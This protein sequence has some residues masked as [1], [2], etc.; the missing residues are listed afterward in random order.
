M[1][2]LKV[3]MYQLKQRYDGEYAPN[4]EAIWDENEIDQNPQGWAEI[5]DKAYKQVGGEYENVAVITIEVKDDLYAAPQYPSQ[6]DP[7]WFSNSFGQ[8]YGV[9]LIVAEHAD[10]ETWTQIEDVWDEY[11]MEENGEGYQEAVAKAFAKV[12]QGVNWVKVEDIFIPNAV[13]DNA[14][15]PWKQVHEAL[16]SHP[17]T[18]ELDEK[19]RG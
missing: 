2:R 12:G 5:V 16:F 13:I 6:T 14:L 18:V 19:L 15:A 17:L 4:V 10:G 8:H 9:R 3:L 1:A 7:A 11:V